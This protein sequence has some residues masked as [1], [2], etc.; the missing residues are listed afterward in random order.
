M[1]ST[2]KDPIC[3]NDDHNIKN[4]GDNRKVKLAVEEQEQNLYKNTFY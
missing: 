3:Y 4:S 2:A 1:A